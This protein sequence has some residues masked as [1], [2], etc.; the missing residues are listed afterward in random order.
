MR[1][2]CRLLEFRVSAEM[3][4]MLPPALVIAGTH[5][6]VGKTTISIALL[7][8][9]TRRGLRVQPSKAGPD[10]IDPTLHTRAAGLSSLN[11]DDWMIGP[12]TNQQTYTRS[13]AEAD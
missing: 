8:A 4:L 3:R 12:A 11:L 9:L 1:S 6:G 10:F 13:S 2:H 7:A 5:S